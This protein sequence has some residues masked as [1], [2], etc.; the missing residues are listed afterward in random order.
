MLFI[1]I[2]TIEI[3][4]DLIGGDAHLALKRAIG[5]VVAQQV[6]Q[7]LIISQVVDRHDLKIVGIPLQERLECLAPNSPEAV[8][9]NACHASS[10]L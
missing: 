10:P 4:G 9:R 2:L 5:R 6:C 8:D 1:I 7:R 3:D